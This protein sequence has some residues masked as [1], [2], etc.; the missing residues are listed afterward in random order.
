[1]TIRDPS[2]LGYLTWL[3]K[4]VAVPEGTRTYHQMLAELHNKE[5]VWLIPNDDNRLQ[6]GLELRAE[7]FG[8]SNGDTSEEGA[9]ALEVLI[10]L[11]RRL[12]FV[13]DGDERQW[14]W[15][16]IC[17][18]E[19]DKFVD[20]LKSGRKLQDLDDRL[21][22]LIWR[23]YNSDGVGGF[24]PLAWPEED[25]RKVELWYQMNAYIEEQIEL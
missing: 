21:E 18:L 22:A 3:K 16:L 17:N 13:A 11:S 24:F 19:F 12:A 2:N 9:S 8:S 25:Q 10:G 20:P 14:A 23:N 15:R 1:M 7:Y 6:D 5:F 4:L